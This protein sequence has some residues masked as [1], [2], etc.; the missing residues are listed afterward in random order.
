MLILDHFLP[1]RLS[2]VSNRVSEVIARAY[3]DDFG[4]NIPEWRTLA[5]TAE[6]EGLTQQQVGQRTCMDKVTVSRAAISLTRRGLIM[7][8]RGDDKRARVLKLTNEGRILY[9]KVVP[10]ALALERRIFSAFGPEELSRLT[11]ALNSIDAAAA[12]MTVTD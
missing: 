9:E 12:P 1:Y 5:V 11:A 10:R 7:R 6:S 8:G 3:R 4:L 2:V